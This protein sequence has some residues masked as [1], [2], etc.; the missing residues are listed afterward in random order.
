MPAPSRPTAFVVALLLFVGSER[1]L[2]SWRPWLEFCRR[3]VPPY[4]RSDPLRTSAEIGLLPTSGPPPIVLIGSSQIQEGLE[5]APFV[6]RFPGRPCVNLGISGATPLDVLFLAE[7]I[8]A[9]VRR[10]TLITGIFPQT[11]HRGPRAVYTDVGTLACLWRTGALFHLTRNECIDDLLFGGLLACS[12][13]L[14]TKTALYHLW[15]VVKEDPMAAVRFE[16]PAQPPRTLDDQPPKEPWFFAKFRGL[17]DVSAK[18]GRFTA[19]QEDALEQV[20]AREVLGGNR[21]IV[22]DFPTRDGYEATLL[23]E[24]TEYYRRLLERISARGGVLVV[25]KH[26]LPELTTEDFQDFT[27][28]R[29][30]GRIKMSER[31]ADILLRVGG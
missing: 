14:R 27:H 20:I 3:Y 6:A 1:A 31:I 12:E 7:R 2:W 13:T 16:L 9:R 17:I 18:P 23:P 22:I 4:Y 29:A 19:M 30:S 28:L 25:G 10:H 5:C 15:D 24:A 8:D 26:D 21:M 11:L